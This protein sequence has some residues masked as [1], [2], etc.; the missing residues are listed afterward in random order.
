MGSAESVHVFPREQ[1]MHLF[2]LK[3]LSVVATKQN[4]SFPE[5]A[6]HMPSSSVWLS[7]D[8]RDIVACFLGL[9]VIFASFKH[10]RFIVIFVC[11]H[12]LTF[13]H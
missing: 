4:N 1:V 7:N 10:I 8:L 9:I 2:G 12:S 3:D 5:E 11:N 13:D 6:K